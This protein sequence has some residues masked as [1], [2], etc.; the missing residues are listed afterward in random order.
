MLSHSCDLDCS[1][2]IKCM[3]RQQEFYVVDRRGILVEKW[4]ESMDGEGKLV[5]MKQLWVSADL[6]WML[7]TFFEGPPLG[8]D[9]LV[10]SHERNEIV[11]I[12]EFF[13]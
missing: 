1:Y 4:R 8:S 2:E 11:T 12:G 10:T 3:G 9:I 13:Q 7:N 6:G 5:E